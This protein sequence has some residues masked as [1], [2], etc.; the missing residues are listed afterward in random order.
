MAQRLTEVVKSQDMPE[1]M[2]KEVI[3]ISKIA[4]ER[5]NTDKEIATF[6]KDDCRAK[7][8]GTWHCIVGRNFGCWVTHEKGYYI[9]MYLG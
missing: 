9:Y 8:P 2:I 3:D 1:D 5:C 6:I 4:I 7:F